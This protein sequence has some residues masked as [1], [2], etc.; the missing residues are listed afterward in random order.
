VTVQ[1]GER[2]QEFD[3]LEMDDRDI[4]CFYAYSPLYSGSESA[5]QEL[6]GET[7]GESES[8]SESGCS[9]NR[10]RCNPTYGPYEDEVF[11]VLGTR[12][13]LQH[14]TAEE[15]WIQVAFCS[16]SSGN[17]GNL[18][19]GEWVDDFGD[20][21]GV[22]LA[23]NSHLDNSPIPLVDHDGDGE[24]PTWIAEQP[25]LTEECGE[26]SRGLCRRIILTRIENT[27]RHSDG[28]CF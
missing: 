28:T 21:G 8:E 24:L 7:C 4:L 14:W 17:C 13:E 26:N 16:S 6:V 9:P 22:R 10:I 18:I 27:E 12:C 19:G 23:L 1:I 5:R 2:E 25:H 15:C 11:P 20:C 3:E